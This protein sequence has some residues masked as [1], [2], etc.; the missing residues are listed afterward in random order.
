MRQ[1]MS[2]ISLRLARGPEA[3]GRKSPFV[4]AHLEAA[5][6]H[7]KPYAVSMADD[8]NP[9]LSELCGAPKQSRETERACILAIKN[10]SRT[11]HRR[12]EP[13]RLAAL[14]SG[15]NTTQPL[16]MVVSRAC[17]PASQFLERES[18]HSRCA[19]FIDMKP[20]QCNRAAWPLPFGSPAAGRLEWRCRSLHLY[21]QPEY[22]SAPSAC[23]DSQ[24]I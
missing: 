4:N 14:R 16:G 2:R 10:L 12:H 6:Q 24:P 17:S 5:N 23:G 21:H 7:R 9:E 1:S 3:A 19:H 15:Y 20:F 18:N 22:P 11:K 13:P 8:R